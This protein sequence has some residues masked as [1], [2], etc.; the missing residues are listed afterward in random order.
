MAR[1][2][3]KTLDDGR[4]LNVRQDGSV[5][6]SDPQSGTTTEVSGPNS[7]MASAYGMNDSSALDDQ[8]AA[9]EAYTNS[10]YGQRAE[11][12]RQ[13]AYEDQLGLQRGTLGVSQG[14]L[15]LD[16]ELGRGN[17]GL[18][19]DTLALNRELGLGNLDISR[20]RL[21]LDTE[22]GRGRLGLDTELG[23]GRLG[24]DTEL[25][26]GNLEVSRQNAGTS[27]FAAETGR[28][29][30]ETE[31]QLAEAR[32]QDLERQYT[33]DVAK[34]GTDYVKTAIEYAKTPRNWLA[35]NMF[36]YGATPI[37][38]QIAQG[39]QL[40]AFGA[41]SSGPLPAMNNITN[42]MGNLGFDTSQVAALDPTKALQ[43]VIK[44]VPPGQS[45]SGMLS[46]TEQSVLSLAENLY[47]AGGTNVPEGQWES[48]DPN[49]QQ[50]LLGAMDYL[51]PNGGDTYLRQ[52][53]R[54]RLPTG[55]NPLA[56]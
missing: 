52:L 22:L 41:K 16:T 42:T 20:G 14:R 54:T 13:Q 2:Y 6:V 28:Y 48:M 23:R 10:S 25:G 8:L 9:I 44:A 43:Q 4:Q 18:G 31:R 47:R 7:E 33:L 19:R 5:Y 34:F 17:L 3:R 24:L 53:G 15:G 45:P 51:A 26:R 29:S 38:Q 39:K 46:P 40:P 49:V 37:Y 55:T 30:A 1:V 56:A 27:R 11:Q 12:L 35:S 21:G 50:T 36:E 32:I